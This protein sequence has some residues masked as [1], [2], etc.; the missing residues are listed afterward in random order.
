MEAEKLAEKR[1]KMKKKKPK[2]ER[3]EINN[4]KKLKKTWRKPKGIHSKKRIH[5]KTK[6]KSPRVGYGN[7]KIIRGIN[8]FGFKEVRIFNSQDLEKLDAKKEV[9]IIGATVGKKKK[10]EILKAAEEREIRVVNA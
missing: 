9:A 7:P 8:R 1:K 5:E 6:G 2:F 3:Q 10:L 4:Q